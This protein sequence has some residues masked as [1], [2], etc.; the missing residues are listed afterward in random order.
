MV[1]ALTYML[2]LLSVLIVMSVELIDK[3]NLPTG[4][5]KSET[6]FICNDL[7][8]MPLALGYRLKFDIGKNIRTQLETGTRYFGTQSQAA[9]SRVITKYTLF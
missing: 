3:Q 7:T 2:I 1:S 8:Y 6:I 5:N 9:A 4:P